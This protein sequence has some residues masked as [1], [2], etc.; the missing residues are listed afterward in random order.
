MRVRD[1]SSISCPSSEGQSVHERREDLEERRL[2]RIN[3]VGRTAALAGE[4]TARLERI[5]RRKQ[6]EDGLWI[7]VEINRWICRLRILI[8]VTP[9]K[10]VDV[11]R[12]QLL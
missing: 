7:E 12:S 2:D 8:S 1:G 6:S 9:Q 11:T 4:A 10:G 5:R 3:V